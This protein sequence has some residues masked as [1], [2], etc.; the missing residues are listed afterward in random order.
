MQDKSFARLAALIFALIAL[1]HALRL[2]LRIPIQ[3]GDRTIPLAASWVGLFVTGA[4]ALI[5]WRTARR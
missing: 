3:I 2:A 1:A 4:L 5:G